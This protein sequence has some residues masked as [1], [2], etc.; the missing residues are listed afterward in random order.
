ML[1]PN[2]ITLGLHPGFH[3]HI[4]CCSALR[5]LCRSDTS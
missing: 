3:R 2:N 1:P 4:G 5:A